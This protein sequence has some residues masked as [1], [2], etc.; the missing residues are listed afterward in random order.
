MGCHSKRKCLGRT[1]EHFMFRYQKNVS[2]K[3]FNGGPQGS[4]HG[5]F[6]SKKFRL[7]ISNS[8]DLRHY[9]TPCKVSIKGQIDWV[10]KD[11]E[12]AI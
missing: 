2:L 3:I 7:Q 12:L 10:K 9:K 6:K 4:K 1:A 8:F 5:K 11:R